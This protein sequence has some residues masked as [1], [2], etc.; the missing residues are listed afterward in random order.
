MKVLHVLTTDRYS[1]AENVVCQIIRLLKPYGIEGF[2]CSLDGP[3][4][5]SVSEKG[6]EFV[7]ME[8]IS[9]SKLKNAIKEIKPDIVH[10][11]D[12]RAGFISSLV[13]GQ[14]PFV[15]HIHNNNF[16]S[17]KT[18]I[19][20][21][22]YYFAAIK[23][24]HIFWVSRSAFEGY[25]YHDRLRDKSS[26]LYNVID[27]SEIEKKA[28][29]G[30]GDVSYD[31]VFLGRL[32]FQKNPHRL[33]I[34]FSKA[35][36]KDSL[37]KIAIV[38]TGE[39]EGE[40]KALAKELK[41]TDNVTFSGFMDNP[42]GLLK[43]SRVMLMTSRWEGT[44]MAALEAMALG[45]PI[46]STPTDGMVDVVKDGTTG[47]LSDEDEELAGYLLKIVHDRELHDRLSGESICRARELMD[48]ESYGNK[49][50]DVYI[51]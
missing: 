21:V 33:L 3:I 47:F 43:K 36:Q 2:Y 34:V 32:T 39:L 51:A 50:R 20:T 45:V 41:I 13:C 7:P 24:K 48:T 40:I 1:G 6:I 15:S 26:V 19:K 22:L 30:G 49:I 25:K 29:N 28:L 4:R 17:R 16:D 27:I 37:L 18:S 14:V 42:Y 5:K 9:C 31:A 44:P 35:V 8:K 23:A 11:H 10:A 12:M 38:G 46:V